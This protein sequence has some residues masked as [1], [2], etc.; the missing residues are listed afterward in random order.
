MEQSV[1][2]V[3]SKQNISS[4]SSLSNAPST[5]SDRFNTDT[6]FFCD[7]LPTE[8]DII[9]IPLCSFLTLCQSGGWRRFIY[10][11]SHGNENT[12][13][14]SAWPTSGS[15]YLGRSPR[16]FGSR[17]DTCTGP[18]EPPIPPRRCSRCVGWPD[19]RHSPH[20]LPPPP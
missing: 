12:P 16:W 19:S 1:V 4:V 11:D 8:L 6:G 14:W 3:K 2:A 20:K 13:Q 15:A 10:Y 5:P 9:H 7:K 18:R 17:R